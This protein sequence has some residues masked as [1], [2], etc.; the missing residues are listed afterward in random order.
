MKTLILGAG[1]M[2]CLFGAK[3]RKA[4]FDVTLFN[5][6]NETIKVIEKQ[7]I[8]LITAEEE[9]YTIPIP[10]IYHANELKKE[11]NLILILVKAFA[12]EEVLSAITHIIDENTIVLTLQN[13]VGNLEKMQK[14]IPHAELGVGGTGSG[15]SILAP[16]V[17]AH[18]TTGQTNI[19]FMKN[20]NPEKHL[21]I[22]EMLTKAGLETNVTTQV[23]SVIWSKLLINVA[24]NSLTAVTRLANGDAILPASGE[25]L[26]HSLLMEA[27]EV[28]EAEGIELLFEDPVAEILNIG[29]EQIA[30]NKSS[31]LTD[32]LKERKT[33]IDVING[34]IV[35][36]G[37]KHGIRTPYNEVMTHL[38][39]TI[40]SSYPKLVHE[41]D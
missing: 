10:V 30:R 33:E 26:V 21:E 14:I 24:F 27:V 23:Q 1:A 37:K 35:A 28:A 41:L 15:A 25:A 6:E 20:K 3:L 31:M 11:Y 18:R 4:G 13:G 2:G 36:Y 9:H 22:S 29:H 32:I 38:V 40:E 19:G 39:H 34:A 8:Q 7:G 16:G 17:I 12:T 5:R